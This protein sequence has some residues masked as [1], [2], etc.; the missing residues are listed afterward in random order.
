VDAGRRICWVDG[1]MTPEKIEILRQKFRQTL[2]VPRPACKP[3]A[4]TG[5]WQNEQ[6]RAREGL[7]KLRRIEL[8]LEEPHPHWGYGLGEDDDEDDRIPY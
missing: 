7:A 3:G 1:V 8:G 4:R 5:Y 2:A 6:Q